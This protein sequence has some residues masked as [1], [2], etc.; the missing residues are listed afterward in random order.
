MKNHET[1]NEARGEANLNPPEGMG[2]GELPRAQE[3]D[4]ET[5]L[6]G[7]SVTDEEKK[8]IFRERA[9]RLAKKRDTDTEIHEDYV[10]VI[11]FLLGSERY[12]VEVGFVREVYTLRDLTPVPCTP[13]YVL[14]IINVRGQVVSVTDMKVLFDLPRK[15]ID[16]H[17]RVL[18]L[19]GSGMEMGI[20]VDTVFG[21]QR[22]PVDLIQS[23]MPAPKSIRQEYVRGVTRDRLV[24]LDAERILSD[25][26][27]IVHEEVGE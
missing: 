13:P 4:L 20:L 10:Q 23:Q 1:S 14:G 7:K 27:I 19:N 6:A 17:S 3:E 26:R 22:I 21:E 8:R 2:D 15:A 11:E 9:R 18:I 16:N 25:D 24:L 5:A 12:A